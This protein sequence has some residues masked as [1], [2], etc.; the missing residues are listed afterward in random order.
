MKLKNILFIMVGAAL[1][2]FGLVNFNMENELGEG[3]LTGVT[4]ILYFVFN[5]D[6][7]LMNILLNIPMFLIG[8]KVLGRRSF[9]YTIIGTVSVSIFIKIFQH[10]TFHIDLHN[11]MLLVT[12]LAGAFLGGGLGIVFRFGGT[13]G[14]ADIIAR[15][16]HK[17]LGWGMGK[18]LLLIDGI[19]IVLSMLTY[20]NTRT[21]IYTLVFVFVCARV[22]DFVQEG[23]YAARGAF[24]ISP[25]YEEISAKI[26]KQ[27]DRG[28]TLL[29]GNGYY[30]REEKRVVYCVVSKNELF[31]LKSIVNSV[32]PEAFMSISEVHDVAGEGFT[33]DAQKKPIH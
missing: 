32:D 22:I 33:L 28:V 29:H 27:L 7:A 26:A 4:L 15:V 2:S 24:I 14:G 20:L 6:P 1:Y 17:Y 18:T 25:H 5:L 9:I 31:K 21:T 16:A 23:A 30:T 3:G 11:D 13:T 12:L 10:F 19:V 8:W